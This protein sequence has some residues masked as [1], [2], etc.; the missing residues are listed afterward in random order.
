MVN[1]I[2]IKAAIITLCLF[3]HLGATTPANPASFKSSTACAKYCEDCTYDAIA[4][5]Y[6]CTQ[7]LR[8]KFINSQKCSSVL[9]PASDHC[10]SYIG[11]DGGMCGLC[12]EG[13]L[14]Q[15]LTGSG[16]SWACKKALTPKCLSGIISTSQKNAHTRASEMCF[17]CKGSY[18]A[19]DLKS[20]DGGPL[21]DPNCARG[22]RSVKNGFAGCDRCKPGYTLEL[23]T[24]RCI[25]ASKPGCVIT[26]GDT[27]KCRLCDAEM[28]ITSKLLEFA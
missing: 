24:I 25:K 15:T 3:S 17:E 23:Y 19:K 6:S 14:F 13:Y 5:V 2:A 7:C 20:C 8:R 16:R 1:S 21:R 12:E 11:Y 18:P 28:G 4:H 26:E 9:A 10:Q 22:S 27:G